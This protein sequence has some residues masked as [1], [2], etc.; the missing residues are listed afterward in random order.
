V[1]DAGATTAST[2]YVADRK[3]ARETCYVINDSRYGSFSPYTEATFPPPALEAQVQLKARRFGALAGAIATAFCMNIK[4]RK[5][6]ILLLR[7]MTTEK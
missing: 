3:A 4:T 6:I 5:N 7:V 2:V 1:N